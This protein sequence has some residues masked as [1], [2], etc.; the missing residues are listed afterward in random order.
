MISFEKS[1][2]LATSTPD[3]MPKGRR[4]AAGLFLS[5]FHVI[6]G[7]VGSRSDASRK[8]PGPTKWRNAPT[9]ERLILPFL[10]C[11]FLQGD[12]CTDTIHPCQSEAGSSANI[13]KPG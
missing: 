8:G 11:C 4:P 1:L 12:I 9:A 5:I 13:P 7:K 10:V 2:Y 6:E 3:A